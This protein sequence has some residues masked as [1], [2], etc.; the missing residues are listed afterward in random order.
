MASTSLTASY[1]TPDPSFNWF[2][3]L[4]LIVSLILALFF[5][6]YFNRLFATLLSYALRAYTWHYYRID[7]D[8]KALQLSLLGGRVFF[9]GIRYHGVNETIFVN[10]GFITWRYWKRTVERTDLT[11]H[12]NTSDTRKGSFNSDRASSENCQNDG[13]GE[14]GGVRKTVELP[15]RV[16]LTIYGLEWF[17]YNRTPAYDNILAGFGYEEEGS[18]NEDEINLGPTQTRSEARRSKDSFNLRSRHHIQS[19][20]RERSQPKPDKEGS[21]GARE[22]AVGDSEISTPASRLLQLLPVKVDCKKGAIV[23]GN[24]NTRSVLTVTWNSAEGTVA[25]CKAGPL[26]LYRQLISFKFDH[27]VMQLRPNPDFDRNQF[28]TAKFLSTVQVS[29]I[30]AKRGGRKSSSYGLRKRKF[31]H[32]IRDLVPYFQSS[33]ESFASSARQAENLP[34]RKA[35]NLDTEWTGLSRYLDETNGDDHE[36]WNSVEYGRYSTILESPGLHLTYFWDIPGRVS[37]KPTDQGPT[38][39]INNALPPEWG[40]DLKIDGGTI[41]YGPWADRERVGLQTV[42]F[43]NFFRDSQPAEQ[44]ALGVLRQSTVFRFRLEIE[45]NLTIRIPSREP[46]KDWLWKGRADAVRGAS[47]SKSK[48]DKKKSRPREG[49]KGHVGADIRPFGWLS[50]RLGPNSTLN[51]AMD[52]VASKNGFRNELTLDLRDS[53]MSSSVN[54]GLLW[55]CPRQLIRCDLSNPLAWNG[56]RTWNFV[57]ESQ[58]M[59]LF[60]LRDHL[61]LLTDLV[62]DWASGPAPRYHTFVPFLYKIDLVFSNIQLFVN[63]NDRNIISN[64]SDLGDNRF[65][66]IKSQELTSNVLIPLDKYQPEQSAVNFKVNLQ[67]GRVEYLVPPWDTLHT[68]LQENRF[69]TL[70]GL[71]IE[72]SYAYFS[73]PSPELIDTLT[74]N[75]EGYV[76]R[77]YLFGF[78]IKSFMAVK[79]N[80]FGDEMHFKTLEEYQELAYANARPSNFTG[81]NPH[82]KSNDMD[83]IV[84]VTVEEPCALLPEGIYDL[85]NCSRLQAASL[86]VDL[87]F[88]NY[89]MDMQF[90]ISPLKLDM[91]AIQPEGSSTVSGTQLF[92]DGLSVYGHRL[93]GQPP[94]EPTYVCNWDFDVGKVIGECSPGFLQCLASGLQSFDFT[95]DNEENSLHPLFPPEIFDVTFLRARISSVHI[96]VLLD[97]SAIVLETQPLS[98]DFNDWADSRFSKRMSV[99]TSGIALAAVDRQSVSR[100]L[101]T[102]D[103]SVPPLGMVELAVSIKLAIRKRDIADSR[104]AQQEHIKTHDQ[105]TH[106]AQWLLYDWEDARP[107][108]SLTHAEDTVFSPSMPIPSMP[109][110]VSQNLFSRDESYREFLLQNSAGSSRSFLMHSEASS[111]R[112]DKHHGKQGSQPPRPTQSKRPPSAASN[113]PWSEGRSRK[114][115][116]TTSSAKIL[117]D[118]NPWSIPEFSYWKLSLSRVDLPQFVIS[119]PTNGTEFD[120][121]PARRMMFLTF[122]D[123]Q[124]TYSNL[125]LNF[126]LGI[127]GHFT[128]KFLYSLLSM[129]D[130]LE[131]KRPIRI[132]DSLQRSVIANILGNSK[133]ESDP[134]RALSVAIRIPKVHLNLVDLSRCPGDQHAEFRD[135]YSLAVNNVRVEFEERTMRGEKSVSG[136]PL[137]KTTV[138]A[139]ID[140]LWVSAEG[141]CTA[142]LEEKAVCTFE[143]RD[144]NFWLLTEP[145]RRSHLQVRDIHAMTSGRSVERLASLAR[146]A[147]ATFSSIAAAFQRVYSS[148]TRR[149]QYLIFI[150]IKSAEEIADP[151]FLTRISSVLRIDASHI[152]Q[153]DSWK[154]LSRIRHIYNNLPAQNQRDLDGICR[155]RDFP[156]PDDAQSSV[157]AGLDQ[158]RAWDLAHVEKSLVMRRIWSNLSPQSEDLGHPMV[159]SSSVKM[160]RC[161]LDPG[162][163]ESM[164]ALENLSS[165]VSVVRKR[166]VQGG[167]SCIHTAV[168]LQLYCSS[169]SLQLRW[170]LVDFAGKLAKHMFPTARGTSSP[171]IVADNATKDLT[172]FH[173]TV[174]VDLGA[175][176]LDAINVKLVLAA[177]ALNGSLVHSPQGAEINGDEL[178]TIVLS[179]K[180]CSS[181]LS[182]QAKVIMLSEMSTPYLS[183][184]KVS[185]TDKE[186][187]HELMTVGSCSNLRF[188]MKEDPLSLAHIADCLIED[189]VRFIQR[190]AKSLAHHTVNSERATTRAKPVQSKISVVMILQDYLVSL[191]LLPSLAYRISGNVARTSITSVASSKIVVDFDITEHSHA[192]TSGTEEQLSTLSVLEMPPINGHVNVNLA[193]RRDVEVDIIVELIRLEASAVRSLL[194]ILTGPDVSRIVS[195]LKESVDVLQVHLT[196]V[197][198]PSHPEPVPEVNHDHKDST[199]LYKS[200]LTIAGVE[201][202]AIAPGLKSNSYSAEMVFNL[203]LLQMRLHNGLDRGFVM[204]YPEFGIDAT[205]IK[206]ELRKQCGVRNEVNGVVSAAVKFHGTSTVRENGQ[207]IRAYHLTSEK[208]NVELFAETAALVVDLAIYTQE[209]FKALDLSHEVERLRRLRKR[210]HHHSEILSSAAG[211]PEIHVNDGD[212]AQNFLNAFYSLK[213]LNIQVAWNMLAKSDWSGSHQPEDLVFSIRQVELSNKKK[214]AAKLRIENMQLQMVPFNASREKRSLNSALM[215]EL[216]FNVA[217]S[218]NHRELWLAFQAAGKSLDIRLTSEFIIPANMIRTSLGAA[219]EA[220]REGKAAW[221]TNPTQDDPGKTRNLFGNK[222]L[223]SLLVDV[224][225]AGATV[226]LQGKQSSTPQIFLTAALNDKKPSESKYGQYVQG[227]TATTATLQAP[228]VAVKVQFDD[229]GADEPALNAEL[230]VAP[231]TNALYPT[232]VPLVKQMTAT[233]K[234]IMSEQQQPHATRRRESSAASKLQPQNLMPE[235]PFGSPDPTSILGR[236]KVNFGLLFSKQEFSLSCQPIARVAATAQF[237]SIYITVNT[238]HSAEQ[239]RFLALSLAFNE[240][241]ASVKHVYSNEPTASFNVDSMVLSLM[242]SKHLGRTSGMSAILRVSPMKVAL[243][244]KQVQDSLLFREIWFPTDHDHP[245]SMSPTPEPEHHE[246]PTYIVQ[247]YQQVASTSVFPWNTTVAIEHVELALDLGSTLGKAEF[248]IDNFWVSSNKTSDSEQSMCVNLDSVRIEGKGRMA[249]NVDMH[250]LKIRTSI[251]WPEEAVGHTPL[252]QAS[253]AFQRLEAK[254]S[255]DYQPF[256]VVQIAEFDFLMYN[257]REKPEEGGERLFSLLEGDKVQVFCTSLTASQTL[258]VYQAWQRLV[259]DKQSAYESSLRELERFLRRKSTALPVQM[260]ARAEKMTA[261]EEEVERIPG[262]LHTG[263]VVHIRHVNLGAF[264]SSFSDNQVFKLEAH[265]AQARFGVSLKAGQIHSS[266]G[267]TLGQLRVG[268]AGIHRPSSMHLDELSIG[269]ISQ[270]A[271]S[272]R[273]GT[274]LKVPRLM[275]GMETWQVPGSRQ[276]DYTFHSTFEGKVDVGWNYSR[277]SFIR[278]MWESHSRALASRLGKPLPPSA[279]RITGGRGSSSGGGDS[280][281]EGGSDGD[282]AA[283][284]AGAGPQDKITAV[285][286][287]PQSKYTY[288]ALEPPIIQTPQL[289]D[290]GEATPPLEWIGLHREK[291]PNVTHQIIIV[292]L[293]EIAKEVEDAYRKILG[294]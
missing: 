234:E 292:S 220:L 24:E 268:L 241:E 29:D 3:L 96:S 282:I 114:A 73:S 20:S 170:E 28:A 284:S 207:V 247:R 189:E 50:L 259:Q 129:A 136:G 119:Q 273:G 137:E 279:V 195:D 178:F 77:L 109:Q 105:R 90:S 274:I 250:S 203:G 85:S 33:V 167:D 225:F 113:V 171:P 82:K 22:H 215:P 152:R 116:S 15:C 158:W 235:S 238:V 236:C 148:R 173:M 287:V 75:I 166:S 36:K 71:V 262:S 182:S 117:Q 48:G 37:S 226:S 270:R 230:K 2:F 263:V 277:I 16:S 286:N 19:T 47:R 227:D 64:P 58:E 256:L 70:D 80:Y 139:A 244:A 30:G 17:V 212:A 223:R 92:V 110:P 251:K 143:S 53:R 243:N 163:R 103:G 11:G 216:V 218:S 188:D 74:L 38:S 151:I 107:P 271:A 32:S 200:R 214:N 184:N 89:Y 130:G 34:R 7:L 43:P 285:V 104:L 142:A 66:V 86:E 222:R 40:I 193:L 135:E 18:R 211:G 199:V 65:I 122:D 237:Q 185:F 68:F 266:L 291:L 159:L 134:K 180:T 198:S 88:T 8:I 192:F 213:F 44:L 125:A 169:A 76:P 233:V 27:P 62:S 128:P 168:T 249:G 127:R 147:T 59:E 228:G 67:D 72:G 150:L 255:F 190:L 208:F 155:G 240:L 21:S 42:F 179:A 141:S 229:N 224:D 39:N 175:V 91:E 219:S 9:K 6:L 111:V 120:F 267:L 257:V 209:R 84:H 46:S 1:L 246:N 133:S 260:Q 57:V 204:E 205:Q 239:G 69:A 132:I 196:D 99:T 160:L 217:Y 281:K 35:Q 101:R 140:E 54:H 118:S 176:T 165:L 157:L 231:S 280:Q 153:H 31:W 41:N 23:M 60:L 98:I 124:T 131:A 202:H 288:T 138:H 121:V 13:Y 194:G 12:P 146:R 95:F 221:A 94:A 248:S 145:R 161:G 181:E 206:F 197:L 242:N 83:V 63:V 294:S 4:E 201:I 97:Q 25:A 283:A 187:K 149:I 245:V 108:S 172:S 232:L 79:D 26:D 258:A 10:G 164:F 49:E 5:L 162:P 254:V 293:L 52:M 210:H 55:Q 78:L 183:F 269:E 154:I 61:F 102:S 252:I 290:M 56:L 261:Q 191:S 106:R 87:R 156:L 93:F 264:P 45:D 115:K 112:S 126:P 174:G 275:A 276:I 51:Y 186:F 278:D 289:R 123:D 265:D 144:I 81:I 253:I 272:S 177:E 100:S 14:Q